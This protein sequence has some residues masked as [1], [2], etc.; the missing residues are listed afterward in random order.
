MVEKYGLAPYLKLQHELIHAQYDQAEGKWHLRIRR[1]NPGHTKETPCY[2]EFED[3]ADFVFCGVG[4][5]SR[6]SW[7]DIKGLK[8][9]KGKLM[10]SADWD[11][12]NWREGVKDWMDKTVGVIGVV[13]RATPFASGLQTLMDMT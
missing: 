8:D 13:S 9:F 3:T 11:T 1:P 7:P 4:G 5:L 6:W 2:E 12:D 10:H